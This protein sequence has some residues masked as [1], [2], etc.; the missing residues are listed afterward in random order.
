VEALA[1]D[2]ALHTGENH[3]DVACSVGEERA[4]LLADLARNLP[5]RS[6]LFYALVHYTNEAAAETG[7]LLH[8]ALCPFLTERFPTHR[9]TECPQF[10]QPP[11][12]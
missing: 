12:T 9:T 5:K 2:T 7:R 8:E 4:V 11:N 10:T 3:N 6:L 1:L